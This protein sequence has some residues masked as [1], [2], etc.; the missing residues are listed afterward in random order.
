MQIFDSHCHL[1]DPIFRPDLDAVM[2]RAQLSEVA[3]MMVVGVDAPSSQRAVNLAG[4]YPNVIA[5]VG[6][7]PH[8][9]RMCTESILAQLQVM[10]AA[11]RVCAWG[12]TGLDFNRMHSPQ[13]EQERWFTRQLIVGAELGLPMIFHERDSQG[14]FLQILKDH[15]GDGRT[16]VVHC[17]SGTAGELE[18]Y[19]ELDLY[20]GIT[21][22]VSIQ[23]RG[24]ALREM[25]RAIPLNRLVVETDAPYLTP[26][27]ERNKHRRNEPAFVRSVL[28]HL[29]AHLGHAPAKLAA[30]LWE[31]TCRLFAWSPDGQHIQASG[32]PPARTP[33]HYQSRS[34]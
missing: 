18:A 6:V 13:K 11:P 31:N 9:A 10:T 23:S 32:R 12:E 34:S 8:D 4:H 7:H 14:R 21:G 5:S 3:A 16:G 20:I 29:A 22:I 25:V 24:A 17:F 30:I 26:A 15:W 27:P 28:L 33:G 2:D 19:L 1:D